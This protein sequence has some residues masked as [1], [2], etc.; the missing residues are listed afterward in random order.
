MK[1]TTLIMFAALIATATLT[2][3]CLTMDAAGSTY[4]RDEVKRGSTVY[5]A[6]IISIDNVVIEG[7]DSGLGTVGGAI[8]GGI[9]G[10]GVGGGTGRD[11]AT[12]AGAIGGAVVGSSVEED[13]T[14]TPALEITVEYEAN[15][16]CEAITQTAGNDHFYVGQRVRVLVDSRGTKRVRP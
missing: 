11:L 2:T 10:S 1:K 14:R 8:L 4:A 6:E 3:G 9:L 7:S 16:A 5:M 13:L 12:A 15:G